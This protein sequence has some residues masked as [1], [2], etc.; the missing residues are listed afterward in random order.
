M[1]APLLAG[2]AMLRTLV[3]GNMTNGNGLHIDYKT[4][5]DIYLVACCL[6]FHGRE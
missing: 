3:T 4:T 5:E 6:L 2:K 1:F